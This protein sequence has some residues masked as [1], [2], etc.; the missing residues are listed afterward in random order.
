MN[1]SRILSTSQEEDASGSPRRSVLPV[2]PCLRS[3]PGSA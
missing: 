1:R 3:R 2:R